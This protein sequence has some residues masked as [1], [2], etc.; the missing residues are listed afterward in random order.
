MTQSGALLS[1]IPS[2]LLWFVRPRGP[3]RIKL[4]D[5][6]LM[7]H[8]AELLEQLEQLTLGPSPALEDSAASSPPSSA[9]QISDDQL[10]E[11]AIQTWRLQQRLD[12]MDPDMVFGPA[13]DPD[14]LAKPRKA[15]GREKKKILDSCRRFRKFLEQFSVEYEDVTGHRY[16]MGWTA[17][18]VMNWEEPLDGARP[19][20][21]VVSK[22]IRPIVRKNGKII[23]LGQVSCL[24]GAEES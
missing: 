3:W 20:H 16:D 14:P 7:P 21:D 2:W 5:R 6:Q 22:T 17:V 13:A 8:P 11:F 19:E 1:H 4:V 18:E 10:A 15:M 12:S 24:A 23:K 9:Q